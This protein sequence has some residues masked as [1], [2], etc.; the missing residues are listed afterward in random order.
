[1][2]EC[3]WIGCPSALEYALFKQIEGVQQIIERGDHLPD[4]DFHCPLMSLPLSFHTSLQNIPHK[5]FYLASDTLKRQYWSEKLYKS[6]KPKVGLVWSGN[7][8]H[9]NDRQRS[10]ELSTLFSYL[11]DRFDYVS[12]QKEVKQTDYVDL[13]NLSIQYFGEEIEDFTDTAALCSLMDLVISVDTSV[14]HLS[15]ALGRPTWI[16]LP[17]VPDWRWLLDRDDSP[18]YPSVKLI[19]QT[20]KGDWAGAL[21][22]LR[23]KLEYY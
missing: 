15:G 23:K 12:L 22:S 8:A 9:S 1:V 20:S 4:F 14:A 7:A 16:L 5:D 11:P 18:W 21:H 10:L 17:F 3:L 6:N 13:C 2:Y 19:R